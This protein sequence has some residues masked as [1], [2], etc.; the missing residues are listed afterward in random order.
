MVHPR[1]RRPVPAAGDWPHNAL[2]SISTHDL[3]TAGGFLSGEHVLARAEAGVLTRDVKLEWAAA[4][5][6]R[7]ALLDLLDAEGLT[8]PDS[9]DEE[10]VLAMHQLLLRT[11]CRIVLA[12]PYDVLGEVRQPNL[13]GTASQYP[14][15]RIPLPLSLED[16]I[17]DARMKQ[18]ADLFNA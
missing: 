12:S 11:P 6:D 9:T 4:T 10:I 17:V 14:N 18:I 2:A 13:P 7:T 15:W 5:A 8:G 16:L 3:P 1:R